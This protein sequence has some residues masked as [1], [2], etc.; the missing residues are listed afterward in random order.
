MV[1]KTANLLDVLSQIG[2]LMV[3]LYSLFGTLVFLFGQQ[4]VTAMIAHK[5]YT[6]EHTGEKEDNIHF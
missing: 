6:E 4:T 2:G 3:V 5:L 1:R